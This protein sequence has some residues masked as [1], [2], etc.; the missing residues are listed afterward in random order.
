MKVSPDEETLL[1][2]GVK[3][4][5]LLFPKELDTYTWATI[6]C[7]QFTQN[8]EYWKQ[9]YDTVGDKPSTVKITFP[10]VYLGDP[11][12]QERIKKIKEEMNNYMLKGVFAPSED[13]MIYLERT[14]K[15]G[16]VRHGLV[17][18]IDLETYEWKP[19]SKAFLRATEPTLV[20]RLPP[21]ME[22][23][24][25]ACIETPHIMLLVNDPD[26]CLVEATGELVKQKAPRYSGKLM[27]DSGSVQ[28]WAIKSKEEIS[29]FTKAL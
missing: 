27:Q 1:K 6:A 20:E 29:F 5:Q 9:V 8:R 2:M 25:G 7:D 10:E 22:I 3:I 17:T 24:R 13:E 12:K 16:R 15:Y 21:R 18:A 28:G 11:D 23:R 19:F 14:T 4:P 26:H